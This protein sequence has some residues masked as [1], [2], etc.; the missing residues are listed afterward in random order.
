MDPI[1]RDNWTAGANNIAPRD[2]LPEASLRS[3]VNVDPLPGGR[4]AARARYQRRYVGQAVR[5]VLALGSKLL[6]ADGEDL[7]EFDTLTNSSRILRA[8]AGAGPMVGDE[9]NGRLYF[10]TADEALEYDGS[11]VRT[12]GVPDV[13][14]QPAVAVALGGTLEAG[15][16]QVAM[17]Y[18][19]QWGREGGTD[20]ALAMSVPAGGQLMVT[21]PPLPAGCTANLYV[22]PVGGSTL[23]L[24][25]RAQAAGV[26]AIG[27]VGDD[28]I[29]CETLL[30]RAPQPGHLVCAHNGVLAVA[31]D[32]YAQLTR[33]MR[34]HLVDRVRDVYQYPQR[35]GVLLSVMGNLFVGADRM[36]VLSS[37][38][39]ADVLQSRALEFPAA[40]G[41]GV[42]LPD[43]RGAWMTQY[44]QAI[45]G[46]DGVRLLMQGT[47]AP[48]PVLRGASGVLDFNGNQLIVS[49]LI[50]RSGASLAS[51]DRFL[52]EVRP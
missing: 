3:A 43:G 36:H 26:V 41:T 23:Y 42:M 33:P 46:P 24:Q 32:R 10:C 18:T 7:V 30:C 29:R 34:P 52:G 40:P 5:A 12:W 48:G 45:A 27:S 2:R 50:G 9:L 16:Y 35:I 15:P 6:I 39:T 4:L 17:T 25:R 11:T 13:L 21:V 14:L 37:V 38:E 44:G 19:D 31:I 28:G 8:I 49:T 22:S 20:R 47:F 1:R 51:S